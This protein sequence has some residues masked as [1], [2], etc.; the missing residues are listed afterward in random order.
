M[1]VESLRQV[2]EMM[3]QF[4]NVVQNMETEVEQRLKA[5]YMS[6]VLPPGT[7]GLVEQKH[8][9]EEHGVGDLEGGGFSVG[10]V[11]IKL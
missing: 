6:K 8:F 1:K 3:A 7:P 10:L 4:K 5:Q 9:E 11:S 2:K